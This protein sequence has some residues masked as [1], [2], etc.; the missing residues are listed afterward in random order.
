MPENSS[1][2][3]TPPMASDTLPTPTLPMMLE[4]IMIPITP[5]AALA[6]MPWSVAR[7]TRCTTGTAMQMQQRMLAMEST[8]FSLPA[9]I[10][11][12]ASFYEGADQVRRVKSKG[13]IMFR[14]RT[15]IMGRAFA[16]ESVAINQWNDHRWEVFYCWKSLG[17]IDLNEPTKSKNNYNRLLPSPRRLGVEGKEEHPR[18]VKDV[19]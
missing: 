7:A 3:R 16:G 19:P 10:P 18:S 12:C 8:I 6:A 13:E 9:S 15:Y 5:A 1:S 2:A 17:I 14:N 4:A 11:Q